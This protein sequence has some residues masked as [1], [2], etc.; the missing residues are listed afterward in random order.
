MEFFIDNADI[1]AKYQ[2]I[3]KRIM[4]LR[5][6]ETHDDMKQ[7]G[8]VYQKALGANVIELRKL[9]N[10]YDKNHL[11]ANKLWCADFR[12]T[13]IVASLLEEPAKVTAEQT[14]RWLSEI[15]T[16]EMLEQLTF[17]LWVYLPKKE[18]VLEQWLKS[19]D[20]KKQLSAIMGIGRLA[21]TDAENNSVLFLRFLEHIPADLTDNYLRSQV[22]RTLGKMA[23][24][25]NLLVDKITTLVHQKRA[26]DQHWQEIWENLQYEL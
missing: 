8:L 23:R 6:G 4:Q 25:D 14:E 17:N 5:N 9:A 24:L 1:E 11:L 19:G 20:R 3:Q 16:N 22:G 18:K 12:E 7:L 2:Q 10:L 21:L 15:D 13:K 26:T